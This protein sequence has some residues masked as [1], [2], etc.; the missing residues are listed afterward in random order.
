[1]SPS[2]KLEMRKKFSMLVTQT[3]PNPYFGK[4]MLGK[5]NSGEL[6]IGQSLNTYDQDGKFIEGGKV[7]KITKITGLSHIELDKAFAGDI[8]SVAGFPSCKVTHTA[9]E[10]GFP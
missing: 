7:T 4:M 8:V 2:P 6:A 5:I 3:H 9:V 1:M 10:D